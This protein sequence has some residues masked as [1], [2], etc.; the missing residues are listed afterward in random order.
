MFWRKKKIMAAPVEVSPA[1]TGTAV[2]SMAPVAVAKATPS[3][4][5]TK[6]KKVEKLPGPKPIPGILQNH[7]VKH[8]G[9]EPNW[10]RQLWAVMRPRSGGEKVSDVR[11]FAEHEAST[12]N[13]KVKDYTTL[14]QNPKLILFEGWVDNETK[15]VELEEKRTMP[16]ITICTEKEIQQQ[17]GALSE[18]GSQVFFYLNAS[19]ASGGP[20]G[21]GAALVELNPKYPE[22]GQKK[23]TLTA[24]YVDG[25][26]LTSKGMRMLDSNEPKHVA[27]WIKE[28]HFKA[29]GY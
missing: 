14:D 17:I 20:L 24:V 12:S 2:A 19:P 25:M 23:Y 7:L 16:K 13:I 29:S 27:R 6:G 28:R 15:K 11:I 10:V 4:I 3:E 22:K 5:E 9:K 26:E 18:P 1:G 8:M 21:R